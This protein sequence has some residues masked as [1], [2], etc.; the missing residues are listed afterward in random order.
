MS[1]PLKNVILVGAS[2]AAA[3]ISSGKFNVSV[4]SRESSTTSFLEGVTVF[5]TDYLPTSLPVAL[6]GQ[7]TIVFTIDDQGN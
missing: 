2:G 1:A 7:D 4:L 6:K 5:K 3:L